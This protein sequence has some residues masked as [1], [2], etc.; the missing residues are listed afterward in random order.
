LAAVWAQL[1]AAALDGRPLG[2][3]QLVVA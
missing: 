1:D 2:G 3:R